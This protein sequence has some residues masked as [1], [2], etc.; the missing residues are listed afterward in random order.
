MKTS[1]TS[2][3]SGMPF[4]LLSSEQV[5]EELSSCLDGVTQREAQERLKLQGANSLKGKEKASPGTVIV[6]SCIIFSTMYGMR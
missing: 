6:I 2:E 4:C 1:G 3:K 5:L